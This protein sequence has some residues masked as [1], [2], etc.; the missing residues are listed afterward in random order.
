MAMIAAEMVI[1]ESAMLKIGK[2]KGIWMKSTT[3]PLG[4][5]GLRN[6]RSIRLPTTPPKAR[7]ISIS[8]PLVLNFGPNQSSA[9]VAMDERTV[10]TQVADPPRENAALSLK[11]KLNRMMSKR[12]DTDSKGCRF[13]TAKNFVNW[14]IKTTNTATPRKSNVLPNWVLF[15]LVL[16]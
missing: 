12:K 1:A 13:A 9:R 10:N 14:S 6:N 16:T 15:G 2:L 5:P 8:H 7:P 3:C 11:T 4:N